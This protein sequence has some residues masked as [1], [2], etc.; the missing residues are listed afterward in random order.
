LPV[1]PATHVPPFAAEQQPPLHGWAVPHDVVHVLVLASQAKPV[2]QSAMEVQ[3]QARVVTTQALPAAEA[4]QS[5]QAAPGWPH[6]AGDVPG[7]QT[8]L[9]QQAPLQGWLALQVVVQVALMPSHANPAGQSLA[10]IQ[11]HAPPAIPGRQVVPM[12]LPVQS[13][14]APPV[15][16]HA[17]RPKPAAQLPAAQQP[18]LQ[19]DKTSPPSVGPQE[20]VHACRVRSQAIRPGQS[21]AP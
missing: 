5:E 17:N 16:P 21:A 20:V 8:P 18:P 7:W 10:E 2:G 14:H 3:P 4:A 19:A 12:L 13:T 1:L 15:A 11:P 9:A 6:A